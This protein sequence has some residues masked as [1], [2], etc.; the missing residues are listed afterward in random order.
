MKSMDLMVGDILL[1][2]TNVLLTA[3]EPSGLRAV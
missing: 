3:T 2:D 1:V